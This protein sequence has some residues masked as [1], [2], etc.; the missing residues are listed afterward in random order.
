MI[1]LSYIGFFFIA[2]IIAALFSIGV[3][4]SSQGEHEIAPDGKERK[5]WGMILYP[6]RQ[7]IENKKVEKVYYDLESMFELSKKAKIMFPEENF[8]FEYLPETN[9]FYSERSYQSWLRCA[10]KVGEK[11]FVEFEFQDDFYFRAWKEYTNMNF[12]AKPI[13]GCYKCYASFW[14][15]I[16]YCTLAAISIHLKYIKF[17]LY[18]LLPLW[19]LFVFCLVTM[20]TLFHKIV[21]E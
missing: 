17:D 6:L 10:E 11:F 2:L 9:A 4:E 14:G 16:V 20:N 5:V 8:D 21:S 7:L 15:T 1:F 3:W 19:I 13:I 12:F 18:V